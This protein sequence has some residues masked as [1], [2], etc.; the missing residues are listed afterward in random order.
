MNLDGCECFLDMYGLTL[1]AS[2][3]RREV[4]PPCMPFYE[5]L[6]SEPL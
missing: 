4:L 5:E 2:V 6:N 1:V 3:C